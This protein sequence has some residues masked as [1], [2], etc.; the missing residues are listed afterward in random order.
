MVQT[1]F[2]S[3]A[4]RRLQPRNQ[5]K[6]NENPVEVTVSRAGG[7]SRSLERSDFW[8]ASRTGEGRFLRASKRLVSPPADGIL[9]CGSGGGRATE[10]EGNRVAPRKS[11]AQEG[12]NGSEQEGRK[13]SRDSAGMEIYCVYKEES[14]STGVQL[15]VSPLR[16]HLRSCS[17][18][19]M[20]CRSKI[21]D[22]V[23]HS[24]VAK[25]NLRV[26]RGRLEEFAV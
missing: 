11:C 20:H 16:L 23:E 4:S 21:S 24:P 25:R 22:R 14:G 19:G 5:I 8:E 13:A 26:L 15:H 1:N 12:R 10:G 18:A 17:P 3:A 2:S 7:I 6:I 9:P